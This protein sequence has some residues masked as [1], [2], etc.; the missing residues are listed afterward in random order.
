M[1]LQM[2]KH[3]RSTRMPTFW[4]GFLVTSTLESPVYCS[5]TLVENISKKNLKTVSAKFTVKPLTGSTKR[6]PAL[7][8]ADEASDFVVVK[9][10]CNR[11]TDDCPDCTQ[12]LQPLCLAGRYFTGSIRMLYAWAGS[13]TIVVRFRLTR[14]WTYVDKDTKLNNLKR[15]L[16]HI[17]CRD[18]TRL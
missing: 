8:L 18:I 3:K 1:P 14:T 6:R 13:K 17:G 9:S 10:A 15:Y 16:V 7:R 4:H 11:R 12:L 5:T 2:T